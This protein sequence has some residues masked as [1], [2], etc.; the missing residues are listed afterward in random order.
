MFSLHILHVHSIRFVDYTDA[1]REPADA[2][3][4]IILSS[5]NLKA[6]KEIEFLHKGNCRLCINKDMR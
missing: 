6:D 4:Q 5:S 3:D 2:T 1:E